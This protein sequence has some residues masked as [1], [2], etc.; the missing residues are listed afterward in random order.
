MKNVHGF[1][2]KIILQIH[3]LWAKK[4]LLSDRVAAGGFPLTIKGHSLY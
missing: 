4:V 3:D 2:G 1:F